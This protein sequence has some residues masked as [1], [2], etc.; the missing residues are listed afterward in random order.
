MDTIDELVRRA[1]AGDADAFGMLFDRLH[2]RVYRYFAARMRDRAEAEDM[3]ATVFLEAAHRLP[4]FRGDGRAFIAWLFTVA[5][6]DL[7]DLRR[8][9]RRHPVDPV[10]EVP[11]ENTAPDPA[12]QVA[13]RM[14]ADR[15]WAALD[16]L[17]DDQREVLLLKF[18]VGLSNQ[19]VARVLNKPVT[20]VKSLQHRGLTTLRRLLEKP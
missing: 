18:A 5:R 4:Q 15:L 12:Q 20:A 2:D 3:T 14:D 16:R 13:D 7:A 11:V 1:A 9:E 8:R 19:E 6:Q 10:E 17:T